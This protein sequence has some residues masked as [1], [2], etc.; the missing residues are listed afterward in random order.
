MF[1]WGNYASPLILRW[2]FILNMGRGWKA[3]IKRALI[4]SCGDKSECK[5]GAAVINDDKEEE[6]EHLFA[7]NVLYWSFPP[8]YSR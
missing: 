8:Y 7:W 6:G 1:G 4:A 5:Q 2:E 3:S